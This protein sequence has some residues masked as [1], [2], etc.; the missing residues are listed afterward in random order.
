M[1]HVGAW[2]AECGRMFERMLVGTY[3]DETVDVDGLNAEWFQISRR[4][5]LRT[6]LAELMSARNRMLACFAELPALTGEAREWFRES[7]EHHYREHAHDLR[8]WIGRKGARGHG[9]VPMDAG[10]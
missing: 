1:V 5:D 2:L 6:A 7:G 4:V 10:P 9:W 8:A 3:V